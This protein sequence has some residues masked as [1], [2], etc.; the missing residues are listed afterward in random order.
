MQERDIEAPNFRIPF[1]LTSRM[2][3][4]CRNIVIAYI[5]CAR[6][7]VCTLSSVRPKVKFHWNGNERIRS[8][9]SAHLT[10]PGTV[11]S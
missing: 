7:P 5:C 1:A 2:P 6:V 3:A 8:P 9:R 4:S 10:A 11:F